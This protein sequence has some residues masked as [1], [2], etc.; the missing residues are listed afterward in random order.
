MREITDIK[1]IQQIELGILEKVHDFCTTNNIRYAICGG[2]LLGAIRHKGFIPW[3]DDIDIHIPRPDYERFCREFKSTDCSVHC[4]GNDKDYIFPYAKVYDNRTLLI[5][6]YNPTVKAGVFIDVFPIDGVKDDKDAISAL[7]Y[8]DTLHLLNHLRRT[9]LFKKGRACWKTLGVLILRPIT[10][11]FTARRVADLIHR[12]MVQRAF[13]GMSKI[14]LLVG[15]GG[16]GVKEIM[17]RS[18]MDV[19]IDVEFAKKKFKTYVG[20][21]THLRNVYGDYMK[22]PPPE[23]RKSHHHFKAWWK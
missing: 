1:E 2:T 19:Y 11:F 21:E 6:T 3:D 20:W 17:P 9:P 10:Y 12:K 14:G 16:Y 5:E 13:D 8:R 7:K 15:G 22:L 23:K 18:V 4:L